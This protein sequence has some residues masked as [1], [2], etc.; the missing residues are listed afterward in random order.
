MKMRFEKLFIAIFLF[1]ALCYN[2]ANAAQKPIEIESE[3]KD[4][5]IITGNIYYPDTKRAQYSTL[6]LLHSLGYNSSRL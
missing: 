1:F 5:S 3:A 4:G 2:C 6:V